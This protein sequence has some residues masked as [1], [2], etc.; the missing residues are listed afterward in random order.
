MNSKAKL[1]RLYLIGKAKS[2]LKGKWLWRLIAVNP[3]AVLHKTQLTTA[4][5]A[6]T[7]FL[8][9]P[10]SE[11]PMSFQVLRVQDVAQWYRWIDS[12]HLTTLT[13]L[14]CK[15]QFNRVRPKWVVKHMRDTSSWLYK[16]K[17][18][19]S[20]N[21]VW[22]IHKDHRKLDRAKQACAKGLGM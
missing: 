4:A 3:E 9:L 7:T 1:C 5:K 6:F 15:E 2:L 13:E 18:W 20:S 10:I 19:R 16:K 21:L 8:C 11:V 17:R 12:M 14:D 22:S